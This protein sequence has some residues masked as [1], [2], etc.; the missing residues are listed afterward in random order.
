MITNVTELVMLD[1][2]WRY[3]YLRD[4]VG[5]AELAL[6]L[7]LPTSRSGRCWTSAS[8]MITNI[9]KPAMLDQR[10]RHDYQRHGADDA[11]LALAT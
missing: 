9:T 4:G 7:R 2:R 1:Q 10:W 11:E 3:D 6:A 5:D 8:A